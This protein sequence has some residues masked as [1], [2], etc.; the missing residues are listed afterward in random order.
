MGLPGSGRQRVEDAACLP[1]SAAL[2]WANV[3][4][5]TDEPEILSRLNALKGIASAGGPAARCLFSGDPLPPEAIRDG[6]LLVPDPDG[7]MRFS[8]RLHR[9]RKALLLTDNP[10]C[11]PEDPAAFTYLGQD[12]RGLVARVLRDRRPRPA[13][14]LDTCAGSGLVGLALW[15]AG[16]ALTLVDVSERCAVLAR[17]SARLNGIPAEVVLGTELAGPSGD[18]DL[19]TA[20]TDYGFFDPGSR[21]GLTNLLSILAQLPGRL[22]PAG[23]AYLFTQ[24]LHLERG[25]TLKEALEK[26]LP[27]GLAALAEE[28]T[29]ASLP[30]E[31]PREI[32]GRRVLGRSHVIVM[33]RRRQREIRYLPLTWRRR[34]RERLGRVS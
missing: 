1:A 10:S 6:V 17:C 30:P 12:G 7:A 21:Y 34:L 33:I 32:G 11:F 14:I 27:A 25:N 9:C 4:R 13:R 18:L 28:R 3:P 16:D 29:T 24:A 8:V 2:A 26:A 31:C 23:S 15:R 19:V 20:C 22:A 5:V